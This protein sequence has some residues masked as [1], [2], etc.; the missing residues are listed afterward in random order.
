MKEQPIQERRYVVYVIRA[1]EIKPPRFKIGLTTCGARSRK[2][3]LQTA[4]PVKLII[5][6]AIPV[7]DQTFSALAALELRL[8]SLFSKRR[9]HGEWFALT[10]KDLDYLRLLR[11]EHVER[12]NRR[13]E[14]GAERNDPAPYEEHRGELC[15]S[16]GQYS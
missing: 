14:T 11:E 3:A 8:H 1:L 7:E 5:E 2:V 4:S 12:I 13:T 9:L 10:S 15:T 6:V 16:P